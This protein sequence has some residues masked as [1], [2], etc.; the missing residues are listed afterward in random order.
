MPTWP[1][2]MPDPIKP[3]TKFSGPQGAVLR[4][5]MSSGPA[6]TRPRFTAAT[7]AFDLS[8]A[9]LSAALLATFEDFYE[10]DLAMG[11]LEFDMA[12]PITGVTGSFRFTDAYAGED[13]GDDAYQIDV[14]LELLP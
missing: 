9:P 14:K 10:V 2:G 11:A 8:F 5:S 6:K 4:T 3:D 1:A 7:R 12:H 13:V